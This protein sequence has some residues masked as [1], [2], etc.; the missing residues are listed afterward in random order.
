[1]ASTNKLGDTGDDD[2][3]AGQSKIGDDAASEAGKDEVLPMDESEL[4]TAPEI[5][6][7]TLDVTVAQARKIAPLLCANT[8]LRAIRCEGGELSVSDLREEEELEW[9]S[10]EIRDV[11]VRDPTLLVE[12]IIVWCYPYPYPYP[13]P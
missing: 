11:E 9:D 5:D 2:D 13:Y 4:K 7:S 8:E 10:E 3:D 1:M 6:L 12:A